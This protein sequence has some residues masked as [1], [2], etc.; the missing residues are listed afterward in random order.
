M[1]KIVLYLSVI[2]ATVISFDSCKKKDISCENCNETNK[3]PIASAGPDQVITLPTDSLLL[4][5]SASSDPDGT[6]S[7]W[8]WTKI[9]GPASF[10]INNTSAPKTVVKNLVQGV[11]QYELTVKDDKGL[12]AKDTTQV[13]VN[14]L[15]QPNHPPVANAGTDQTVTL[16]TNSVNLDGSGSTDPDNNITN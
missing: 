4:D 3:P 11:Y 5:G 15:S 9:S 13:I 8:L 1:M 6:I 7:V 16:P 14:D 12:S 2:V 10:N